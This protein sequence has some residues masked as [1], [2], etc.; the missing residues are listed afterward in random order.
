MIYICIFFPIIYLI[1]LYFI[2]SLSPPFAPSLPL[3]LPLQLKEEEEEE[4]AHLVEAKEDT[5]RKLR[6]RLTAEREREERRERDEAE[7]RKQDFMNL[8]QTEKVQCI[9][10]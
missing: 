7:R 5:L 9:C 6:Q 1:F 3:A 10:M 8:L 4:E 2:L